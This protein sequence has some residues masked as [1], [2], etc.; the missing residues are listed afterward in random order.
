MAN[1]EETVRTYSA[2]WSETDPDARR[3]LL[4][5]A[6]A[7]TGLY[8]DPMGRADGR[9]ALVAHIGGVLSQF[10]GAGI[11]ITSGV[12][13]HNNALRFNWQMRLGDGSIMVEGVDYGTLAEDG[14]LQSITGFFGPVPEAT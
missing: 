11:E 6:W 4:E 8:Q 2:A 12:D 13:H 10:P 5:T 7:D 14:R 1:V 3:A 9:D